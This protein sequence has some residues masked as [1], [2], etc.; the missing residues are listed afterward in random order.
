MEEYGIIINS[1]E[2]GAIIDRGLALKA[3][4]KANLNQTSIL[5]CQLHIDRNLIAFKWDKVIDDWHIANQALTLSEHSKAMDK[6]K[7]SNNQAFEYISKLDN[8]FL[9][10]KKNKF[11]NMK[12]SNLIEQLNSEFLEERHASSIYQLI[13]SVITKSIAK[14]QSVISCFNII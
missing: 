11:Y 10:L 5:H 2:F 7:K 6:I 13:Y 3:A 9:Y 8:S 14:Q 1:P 4:V 12:T